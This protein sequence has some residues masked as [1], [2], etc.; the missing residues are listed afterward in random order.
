MQSVWSRTGSMTPS[1]AMGTLQPQ[2]IPGIYCI[3][4]GREGFD[5]P[6]LTQSTVVH[7]VLWKVSFHGGLS[8]LQMVAIIMLKGVGERDIRTTQ[9][10]FHV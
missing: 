7:L 6:C 9:K 3:C 2:A 4:A 5:G 1:L 8:T 10:S